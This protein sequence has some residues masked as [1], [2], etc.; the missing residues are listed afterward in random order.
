MRGDDE[1][2]NHGV[3]QIVEYL[4]V[5]CTKSSGVSNTACEVL[6]L[7]SPYCV[8]ERR[9]HRAGAT[10]VEEGEAYAVWSGAFQVPT[11]KYRTVLLIKYPD[12]CQQS[13]RCAAQASEVTVA[14]RGDKLSSSITS[15]LP[16]VHRTTNVLAIDLH[17]IPRTLPSSVRCFGRRRPGT[18]GWPKRAM[19][20]NDKGPLESREGREGTPAPSA[21][22]GSTTKY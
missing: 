21:V 18:N 17:F 20:G 11:N 4:Q 22:R 3:M 14:R 16:A 12:R 5:A 13:P 8:C 19:L 2:R 1:A 7:R 10:A 9:W 15:P 6:L